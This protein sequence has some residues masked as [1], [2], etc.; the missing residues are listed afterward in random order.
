[1]VKVLDDNLTERQMTSAFAIL[2][3]LEFL[4]FQKKKMEV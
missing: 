2:S 3:C 4:F 1:M